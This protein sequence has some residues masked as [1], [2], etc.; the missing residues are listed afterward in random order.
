MVIGPNVII[1]DGT[2]THTH[3]HT[4]THCVLPAVE[5]CI[6][7]VYIHDSIVSCTLHI[8][9][10]LC[11]C[12]L[13]CLSVQIDGATRGQDSLPCLG[14]VQ[15][16]GLAVHCGTMG[17]NTCMAVSS[18]FTCFLVPCFCKHVFIIIVYMYIYV[19]VHVHEIMK[20]YLQCTVHGVHGHCNYMYD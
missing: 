14:P 7:Y 12:I 20:L 1:E 5:C 3:T 9:S 13:R 6:Q 10:V 8:G 11:S 18:S 16:S 15:H 2:D 17:E 19:H 4:H